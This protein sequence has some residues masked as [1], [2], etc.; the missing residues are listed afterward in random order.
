[1]ISPDLVP[2][3][4]Q[5]FLTLGDLGRAP[6][7]LSLWNARTMPDSVLNPGITTMRET[8]AA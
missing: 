2:D 4:I 6:L 3:E 1:M 7:F 8:V 5:W